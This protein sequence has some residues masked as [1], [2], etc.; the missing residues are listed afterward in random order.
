MSHCVDFLFIFIYFWF[1]DIYIDAYVGAWIAVPE[2]SRIF[3]RDK[4]VFFHAET[5]VLLLCWGVQEQHR[6][7]KV[8]ATER[9]QDPS[10]TLQEKARNQALRLPEMWETI[11]RPGGLEDSREELREA[12]VLHLWVWFQTQEVP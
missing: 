7:S 9:F 6:A 2:G 11:R 8:K 10:D 3:E 5:A 12:L 4:T 1:G